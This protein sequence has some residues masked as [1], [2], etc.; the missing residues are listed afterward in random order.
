MRLNPE[1]L[2]PAADDYL[3]FLARG[4][5]EGTVRRIVSDR[6]RLT[7]PDRVA[8][9]RGVLPARVAEARRARL[10]SVDD[11]R[12]KGLLADGH[13]VLTT[14]GNYLRGVPLFLATDGLLRDTGEVHGVGMPEPIVRGAVDL[15]AA[16]LEAEQVRD[17]VVSTS[18]GEILAR[19]EIHD[20]DV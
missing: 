10:A 13:N 8:L 1:R 20:S 16:W 5:P 4:Y 15:C 11:A 18:D 12:S 19:G 6:H 14:V 17:R 2:R 9:Y 3:V 7:G